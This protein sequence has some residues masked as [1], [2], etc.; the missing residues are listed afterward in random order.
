MLGSPGT[1][2]P[3]SDAEQDGLVNDGPSVSSQSSG[4]KFFR[5]LG[6]FLN[7]PGALPAILVGLMQPLCGI[8]PILYFSDLTFSSVAAV[9]DAA[10]DSKTHITESSI[11][12]GLAKVAVLLVST[13]FLIDRVGRR[14]LLL[15]SGALI[16]LSMGFIGLVLLKYRTQTELLLLGFCLA[17]GSYAIGWN[18]VPYVYPS[19]QLPTK[20]RT[21]GLSFITV[22][23]RVISVSNAY[24]YP[25]VGVQ[26]SYIWFFTYAGINAIG[27]VLVFLIV[28]ETLNK[29]LINRLRKKG[30]IDL[31]S[32]REEIVDHTYEEGATGRQ[33]EES[34][35]AKKLE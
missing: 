3:V 26:N 24:L 19:E 16:A 21:F 28:N 14:T 35:S 29:P 18:I 9:G 6:E 32:D 25:V 7:A 1:S 23:G 34:E 2:A 8:G 27:F 10:K 31:E 4:K 30:G 17:V 20:L 22:V 13:F 12:I 15:C 5:L 11:W 33:E